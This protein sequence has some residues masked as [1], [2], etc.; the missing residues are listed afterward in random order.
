[1]ELDDFRQREEQ[2]ALLLVVKAVR[3]AEAQFFGHARDAERLAG[4]AGAKNV[5]RGNVRHRH[6]MDVAVRRL[7][8]IGGVG[9]L[10]VFVPVGGEHAFAPG[11]LKREPE[12]ADAAEQI[13][14]PKLALRATA[15]GV[16]SNGFLVQI[17][18]FLTF[19]CF[20]IQE[21][22]DY[23]LKGLRASAG[24]SGLRFRR[25]LALF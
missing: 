1:V 3:L 15:V 6:G 16:V 4:K 21:R 17:L 11:T 19:L 18:R 22:Q 24:K 25:P 12:A 8:E 7:A 14:K 10:R 20:Q 2:V 5:V 13:N 23:G 9:L